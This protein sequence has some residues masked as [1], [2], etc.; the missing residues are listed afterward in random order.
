MN[1]ATHF[2]DQKSGC[3]PQK[4]TGKDVYLELI[5]DTLARRVSNNKILYKT[6]RAEKQKM[7]S[8]AD[9]Q[10]DESTFEILHN[11]RYTFSYNEQE[12]EIRFANST[13]YQVLNKWIE[14]RG[15][16]I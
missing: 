16:Y 1:H 5:S 11:T 3:I 14:S 12:N 7:D 13:C 6:V 10:Y 9:I 8:L 2:Q 4:F 15:E